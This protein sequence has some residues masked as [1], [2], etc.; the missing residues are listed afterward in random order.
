MDAQRPSPP[1]AQLL[2][3]HVDINLLTVIAHIEQLQFHIGTWV[4]GDLLTLRT[5]TYPDIVNGLTA[6]D[7]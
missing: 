2:F 7:R 1:D 3:P 5:E 4:T 6:N